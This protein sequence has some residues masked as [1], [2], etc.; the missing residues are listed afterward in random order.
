MKV[1]KKSKIL[2]TGAAG[3][4]GSNLV[5]ELVREG[6]VVRCFLRKG[7]DPTVL[8]ESGVEI[9]WGDITDKASLVPAFKEIKTVYHLAAKTDFMGKNWKEYYLPNVIGTR[10]L[11]DLAIKGK[12]NKFVFFF[13]N[14]ND[15]SKKF[16]RAH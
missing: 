13:N 11:A 12:V 16:K 4:I 10:N 7:D 2:V 9:V 14:Q 5:E 8:L 15:R 1:K 3:F 6:E